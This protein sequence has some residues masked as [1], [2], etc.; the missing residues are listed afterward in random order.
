MQVRKADLGRPDLAA[1]TVPLVLAT[2]H[3][4]AR[5][6]FVEVLDIARVDLSRGDL[7][8][9]ESHD[10]G[11]L[12]IGVIRNI[13]AEGNK[14]RGEAVFGTSARASE[15]LA[16]VMAGIVTGVSIGYSLTD[17]GLP[18]KLRDGTE[19]QSFG[20]MPYEC[21]LVA[22]PADPNA[23]FNR[24]APRP[25]LS[26]ERPIMTDTNRTN[27]GSRDASEIIALGEAHANRGGVQLAMQFIRERRGLQEFRDAILDMPAPP[28]ITDTVTFD[29]TRGVEYSML[30]A[31]DA[32]ITG[33]W[34][35]A[36]F[37]REMSQEMARAYGRQPR[38]IFVPFGS[39]Q[40]RVMSAGGSTTGQALVPNV[41]IGFIEMLRNSARVLDAGATVMPGLQGNVDIPRQTAGAVAEWLAED[42]AVTPSD[43]NFNSVTLT[44]K[45][46][47]ALLS[48]TRRM[49]HSAVPEMEGLARAD[50]ARQVALA[51][52]RAALHGLGSSNQPTG[53]YAASNVNAV[54]MGGVPTFGKLIDMAAELGTDN[55]LQ[56]NLAFLTTPGMA[57]KL[58]QTVVASSTDTRMIWEGPLAEGKLAGYSAYSTGQVSATL[59]AGSEHGLI[60]GDFSSMIIGIWGGGV[61]VLVD[62]YS[63]ADRGR[64][65]IT[66]FLDMDIALR[67]PESFCKATGATIA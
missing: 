50:L 44:P 62:P 9:I 32:A 17:E 18:I 15:V 59:G 6:G 19:A 31:V 61:D 37:E 35:K 7:P 36:G 23:G 28:T 51:M 12:N 60:L 45:T 38:G 43:M 5:P 34:R 53:I 3:P 29:A 10:A 65:R 46:C 26:I 55:A 2:D 56:G 66:A 49:T 67:H 63:D 1:R 47:G 52:D 14:L 30:R 58:A 20:F 40:S 57:G 13:R 24:S 22:V 54:A 25:I 4:V 41:H 16:D 48:W 33:D 8:L 64:V 11:R 42:G 21:S 39:I 27:T